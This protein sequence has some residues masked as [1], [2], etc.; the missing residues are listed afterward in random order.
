MKKQALRI[1]TLLSLL[2]VFVAASV[3]AYPD[4][5]IRV[6]IPFAFNVGEKTLPAG[7]YT[8][9][10]NPIIRDAL[11]VC[12]ADCRE[13]VTPLVNPIHSQANQNQT[14][15][16]FHRYGSQYFL[17]QVWTAGTDVGQEFPKSRA[18]RTAA[19]RLSER[20]ARADAGPEFV[21]I[22]AQ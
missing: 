11:I 13:G 14:K 10:R 1:F 9:E 8:V 3:Y 2:T 15:L 17:A 6:K 20:L 5:R 21:S 12:S 7:E 4:G 18:E 16:I 19:K 22:A